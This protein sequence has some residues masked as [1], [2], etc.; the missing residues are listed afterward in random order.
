M[1]IFLIKFKE[2]NATLDR[3]MRVDYGIKGYDT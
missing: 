3:Q 1:Y 2:K